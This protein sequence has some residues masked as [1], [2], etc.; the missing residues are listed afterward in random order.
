MIMTTT[1]PSMK[2][3]L[4]S[5]LDVCRV[6]SMMNVS[7]K[8]FRQDMCIAFPTVTTVLTSFYD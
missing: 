3:K 1:A 4:S 8:Y 6:P 5:K 7:T 2:L